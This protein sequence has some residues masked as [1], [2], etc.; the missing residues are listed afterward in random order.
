MPTNSII[1][2]FLIRDDVALFPKLLEQMLHAY[3]VTDEFCQQPQEQRIEEIG[4]YEEIKLLIDRLIED[5]EPVCSEKEIIP[6]AQATE[7][8]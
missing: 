7:A 5:K 3:I 8:A 1:N 4:A 2:T 6:Q